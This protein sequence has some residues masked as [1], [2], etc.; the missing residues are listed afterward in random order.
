[1]LLAAFGGK[2]SW[3]WWQVGDRQSGPLPPFTDK[4]PWRDDLTHTAAEMGPGP[5]VNPTAFA[6]DRPALPKSKRV[7]KRDTSMSQKDKA[8]Q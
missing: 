4:I 8:K 5:E 3:T 1:L 2:G 6:L 7:S